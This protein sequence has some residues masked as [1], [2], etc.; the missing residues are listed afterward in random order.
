MSKR[1]STMALACSLVL[2]GAA[3]GG[4]SGGSN[5]T[6]GAVGAPSGCPGGAKLPAKVCKGEGQLNL[7]AW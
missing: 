3:C 1:W 6:T 4:S 5:G 2:V 7:I